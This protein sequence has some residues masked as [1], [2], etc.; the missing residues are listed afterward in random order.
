MDL[1]HYG[2]QRSGTNLLEALLVRRFDVRFLNDNSDRGSPL[3]KHVRLYDDKQLIP[4]PQYSN[5]ISVRDFAEFEALF[6]SAPA[7]YLVISKD[8]YSWYLS[9]RKWA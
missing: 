7:Y 9:Y 3:Q 4:E 6:D 8:P 2:L 1:L 5:Q